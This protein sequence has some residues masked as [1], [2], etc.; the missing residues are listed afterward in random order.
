MD[1]FNISLTDGSGSAVE[2]DDEYYLEDNFIVLKAGDTLFRVPRYRLRQESTYLENLFAQHEAAQAT[3]SSGITMETPL[4]IDGISNDFKNILRLLHPSALHQAE[5]LNRDQWI[6]I[7][8]LSSRLKL[9][10][11]RNMAINELALKMEGLSATQ[12]VLLG[13]ELA[14]AS[15]VQQGYLEFIVRE[16]TIDGGEAKKLGSKITIELFR[17]RERFIRG[18]LCQASIFGELEK[19]FTEEFKKIKQDENAYNLDIKA[20]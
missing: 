1:P 8:K 7:M 16:R 2:K 14:I 12:F 17:L 9:L 11:I 6:G 19:L 5:L 10:K 13:R 15:W 20:T 4:V 18:K 3:K